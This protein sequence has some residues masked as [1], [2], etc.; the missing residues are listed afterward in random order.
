MADSRSGEPAGVDSGV[1]ASRVYTRDEER[2]LALN[3]RDL[4]ILVYGPEMD[5]PVTLETLREF[6]RRLFEGVRGHA[7]QHRATDYG[8]EY[9]IFG[10][11]RSTH[12]SDVVRRLREVFSQ[13]E[14]AVRSFDA[15]GAAPD[16][17]ESAIRL[18]AWVQANL[19]GIHPFEDGNGR[20]TRAFCDLLLLRLGLRPIPIEVV[21]AE[22]N[23]C[24]NE[25]FRSE[26]LQP[27]VD[28]LIR[29]YPL[30]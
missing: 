6:H 4:V 7:G 1:D 5:W 12:R 25:Y 10:P 16:Y 26:N 15:N 11:N 19:V 13:I 18:V 9:L 30:E 22:Y 27:F 8:T 21:K 14:R 20:S 3:L 28:L 29:V 2:Q 17:E 23:E 24:L